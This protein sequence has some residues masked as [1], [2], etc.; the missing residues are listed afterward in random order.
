MDKGL[1]CGLGSSMGLV[2]LGNDEI[3]YSKSRGLG[4]LDEV[5]TKLGKIRSSTSN[6]DGEYDSLSFMIKANKVA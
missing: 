5:G 4:S 1:G 2:G 3:V 6:E